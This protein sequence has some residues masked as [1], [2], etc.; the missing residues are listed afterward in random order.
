MHLLSWSIVGSIVHLHYADG[1]IVKIAKSDFDRC[2]GPIVSG[3]KDVISR[4]F[5]IL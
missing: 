3:S 4:D 5:G 2:F 1:S